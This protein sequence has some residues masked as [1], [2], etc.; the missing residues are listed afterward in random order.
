[1]AEERGYMLEEHGYV[2]EEHG[3]MPEEHG[4]MPEECGY[5]LVKRVYIEHFLMILVVR[6]P[7]FNTTRVV[8]ALCLDQFCFLMSMIHPSQGQHISPCRHGVP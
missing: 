4:Y 5:M 7:S 1:V 6:Q 3:Y 8:H 2:A